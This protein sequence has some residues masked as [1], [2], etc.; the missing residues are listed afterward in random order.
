MRSPPGVS[1]V[2]ALRNER[3]GLGAAFR[4]L[5]ELDAGRL[6]LVCVEGGSTDG[7]FEELQRLAALPWRHGVLVLRQ[8]GS[9]KKDAVV[10]G[11]RHATGELAFVYDADGEISGR[12]LPAFID[13]LRG[14][15]SLFVV[16]TRLRSPRRRPPACATRR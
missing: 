7:T 8:D 13:A 1:L 12:E 5:E 16:A 15:D 9:G 3:G 6:E 10:K 14:S 4:E 11:L 2:M